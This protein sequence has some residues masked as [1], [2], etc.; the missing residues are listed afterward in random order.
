MDKCVIP[1]LYQ[2]YDWY[3]CHC[4]RLQ[5]AIIIMII[6]PGTMLGKRSI[7]ESKTW[8]SLV[9]Q[10]VKDLALSLL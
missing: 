3:G 1:P 7:D 2:V 8:S 4:Q 9:A 5:S 10:W 6:R